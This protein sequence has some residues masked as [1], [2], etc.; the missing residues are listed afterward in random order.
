MKKLNPELIIYDFDGV[1]VDSKRAVFKFYDIICEKFG[2]TKIDYHNTELVKK[3][4]MFTTE[5]AL[6]ILCNDEKLLRK[7]TKFTKRANFDKLKNYISLK[8]NIDLVL[9]KLKQKNKNTAIFTNRGKSVYSL[10]K[11][12]KINTYFDY[13]VTCNDVSSPKPSSEGLLK[14]LKYFHKIHEKTLYI[15]DSPVDK[16]SA[17]NINVPFLFY[18]YTLENDINIKDHL[19]LMNYIE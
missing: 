6:K 15:G 1:I 5:D 19:D 7:I 12:F 16:I 18:N 11:Y 10:L 3:I 2:L 4:L 9:K 13:V 17:S 14:I 8:P